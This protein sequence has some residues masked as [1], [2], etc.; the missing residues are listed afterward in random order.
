MKNP[1]RSETTAGAK[2]PARTAVHHLDPL[3]IALKKVIGDRPWMASHTACS[4][5]DSSRRPISRD[6]RT[7]TE[8]AL[9]LARA[10]RISLAEVWRVRAD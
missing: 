7:I 6:V 9:E 3:L 4:W 2:P 5:F 8:S 10:G 1:M